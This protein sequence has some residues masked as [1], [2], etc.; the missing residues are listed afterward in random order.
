MA[1]H[2]FTVDQLFGCIAV[3]QAVV[4]VLRL[5]YEDDMLNCALTIRSP[6]VPRE[7]RSVIDVY[8]CLGSSYFRRAYRMSLD[9][10]YRLHAILL[11]H[12]IVA[13]DGWY[14]YK[15]AGGR[16][17]GNY[18]PPPIP[19]GA[20]ST[21]VRLA[22]A[23]RYFA[24]GSAYDIAVIFGISYCTVIANVWIVVQAINNT[25]QFYISYPESLDAQRE[26]AAG[27][28]RASTPKINNCAG[29]IDG[30]LIWMQKPSLAEARAS[31]IDQK[32]YLCGRKHKFGLNCQA[33]ADSRG[34]FLDVSIIYGGSTADCLAFEGSDLYKRLENG[35]MKKDFNGQHPYVLFGDNAY[36]NSSY[37]ATPYPNVANNPAHKSNDKYNF[38]HSQLRIRV[39]CAFGMLVQRWGL[40]R[41]AMPRNISVRR[42][43][44]MVNALMKLHNYCIN[45]SDPFE[46]MPQILAR[47][48]SHIMNKDDGYVEMI[49]DR[50]QILLYHWIC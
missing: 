50:E 27:F 39:E 7:R 8:N 12:I 17:G 9:C 26:I 38:Y 46:H 11:P 3:V 19:N 2:H 10:F 29:A 13:S 5:K 16:T 42:V 35:L 47:D 49:M 25:P 48:V 15:K 43:I 20:V 33:V 4:H 28:E 22:S 37:M 18:L 36:L 24:G 23:I 21:S 34:Q 14:K 31:G 6:I 44:A 30:I 45:D 41:S 40:L 32:K 1:V